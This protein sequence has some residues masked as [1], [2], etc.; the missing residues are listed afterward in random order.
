MKGLD[1]GADQGQ[2][3]VQGGTFQSVTGTACY[4][5]QKGGRHKGKK[6]IRGN[7]IKTFG[8]DGVKD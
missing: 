1:R 5:L 3:V 4:I 8:D 7:V 6:K 2:A